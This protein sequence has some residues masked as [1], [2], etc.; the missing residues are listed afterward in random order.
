MKF[1]ASLLLLLVALPLALVAA[2]EKPKQKSTPRPTILKRWMRTLGIT[3]EKTNTTPTGYKG[4]EMGVQVDPAQVKV[5]EVKQIKVSV[6][7]ANRG[8]NSVQL[9]FPTSQRIEVLVKSKDG[10]TIEQWSEDQAFDSEP[11]MVS[12]NPSER[13]EYVVNVATRDMVADQS[14]IVE[15]FFPNFE[16]LRK[17]VTV[18]AIGATPATAATPAAATPTPKPKKH[19]K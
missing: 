14:Y 8:K 12:I 15:A 18:S 17:S 19:K 11:S 10:K 9:E 7:L 1:R 4:L 6:T 16:A 3:K 5:A 2:E 13:L